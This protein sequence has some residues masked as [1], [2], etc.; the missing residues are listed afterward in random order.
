MSVIVALAATAVS[1]Q[2]PAIPSFDVISITPN[3]SGSGAMRASSQG[4]RYQLT[5]GHVVT[6]IMTAYP[7][8]RF[9]IVGAPSWVADDRFDVIATFQPANESRDQV[10]QMMRGLLA[11]RFGFRAHME[12]KMVDALPCRRS[13]DRY[14]TTWVNASL[15]R[16]VSAVTSSSS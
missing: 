5:N 14:R 11:D 2:A 8:H 15:T 1:A 10:Q 7:L 16:Q 3:K 13:P 6:L 12:A 9:E 4:G